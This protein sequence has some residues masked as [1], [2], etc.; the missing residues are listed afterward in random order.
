[1]VSLKLAL[2]LAASKIEIQSDSQLVVGQIQREYEARDECMTCYL[3]SVE[4]R[5]AKLAYWRVKRIPREENKKIDALDGVVV[6]LPSLNLS[7]YWFTS[8]PCLLLH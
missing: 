3:N 1:M 6:V 5:L 2:T 8:S 7:R 4:S